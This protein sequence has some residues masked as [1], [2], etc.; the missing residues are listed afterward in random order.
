[1]IPLLLTF[2][3]HIEIPIWKISREFSARHADRHECEAFPYE[4]PV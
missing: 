1:M 3:V 4:V 2:R